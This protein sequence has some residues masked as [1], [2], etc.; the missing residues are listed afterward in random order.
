MFKVIALIIFGVVMMSFGIYSLSIAQLQ[1]P[2]VNWT[3]VGV[4]TIAASIATF[5]SAFFISKLN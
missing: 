4:V 3:L 2:V 1:L 5:G